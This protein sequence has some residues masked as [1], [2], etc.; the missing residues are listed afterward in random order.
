MMEGALL[1]VMVL[2][3]LFMCGGMIFGGLWALTRRRDRSNV[4]GGQQPGRMG[5]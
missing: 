4:D 2:F 5:R 1:V 3:M